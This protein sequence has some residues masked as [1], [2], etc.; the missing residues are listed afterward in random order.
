LSRIDGVSG[1]VVAIMVTRVISQVGRPVESFSNVV[2]IDRKLKQACSIGGDVAPS[3]QRL[4]LELP[5]DKDREMVADFIIESYHEKNISVK[6]KYAY[7]TSLVYLSRYLNHKKSFEDM[8]SEDIVQGYLNNSLKRPLEADPDQRWVST[9]NLRASVFLKFFKWLTQRDLPSSERQLSKVPMLKGLRFVNKKGPKTH[10]KPTDLWTL[11]ED[12]IFLRYVEDPRI[13]CYHAMSRDTSA[14]P[15]ELLAVKIGDIKMKRAGNNNNNKMFAEVEIGR[16]GKTKKSRIVPLIN[17]LP[18]VKAWIAQHPLQSGN[19]NAYLFVSYNNR[20][21]YS[22]TPL[23]PAS[24]SGIYADLR[25]KYFPKLLEED[26]PDVRPEDK[27][28]I[29]ELLKKPWN[30]YI[31]RH[32]ALTEK[33]RLVNEYTFRQHGGWSKDSKMIGVYTHELGGESSEDILLACGIDV[34]SKDELQKQVLL[35]SKDCPHCSEPNK[36]DAKFCLA[37]KMVLTLDEYNET[38]EE[39]RK[40]GEAAAEQARELQRKQDKLE[41]MQEELVQIYDA[42]LNYFRLNEPNTWKDR[43]TKKAEAAPKPVIVQ[44]DQIKRYSKQELTP[45]KVNPES[46]FGLD[47]LEQ[48]ANTTARAEKEEK[49]IEEIQRTK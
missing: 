35:K 13:A 18:Y 43:M 5:T 30:P 40:K 25:K 21:K 29:R 46:D 7:I 22:N 27:I 28:K 49:E 41:Q 31:R 3:F 11:E 14:R 10:V 45:E 42:V 47:Y 34:K 36:P 1:D 24:L 17:S 38:L 20:S 26:R 9:F 48:L 16:Y 44:I 6:T 12:A 8:T 15:G 39:E 37:C 4:L 2:G 23:K 19:P 32:T 33:A